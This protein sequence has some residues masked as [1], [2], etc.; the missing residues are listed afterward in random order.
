MALLVLAREL[1]EFLHQLIAGGD[2]GFEVIYDGVFIEVDSEIV[3]EAYDLLHAAVCRLWLG[4]GDARH[5]GRVVRLGHAALSIDPALGLRVQHFQLVV[6]IALAVSELVQVL[7]QHVLRWRRESRWRPGRG[8][9]RGRMRIVGGRLRLWLRLLW[10]RA[11]F[12]HRSSGKLGNRGIAGGVVWREIRRIDRASLGRI[13]VR[14]QG[15]FN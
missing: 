5:F 4:L 12:D 6:D 7:P 3:E 1:L 15:F 8:R 11:L 2:Q 10:L 13:V 14:K 9:V